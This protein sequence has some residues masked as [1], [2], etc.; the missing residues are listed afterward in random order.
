LRHRAAFLDAGHFDLIAATIAEHVRQ[1]DTSAWSILDAGSGT[2]HHLANIAKFFSP[3]VVGLGLDSS[4]DAARKAARHWPTL[5][6]AV[7]DLWTEWPVQDAAIDLLLSI[8]AP[9]NFPEVARV[10]RPAGRL[11]L[12]YP[13]TD[14]MVELRD[15]FGLMRR[16]EDADKRYAKMVKRFVGPPNMHRLRWQTVLDDAA[17][18]S[19]IMMGPNAR[20]I[21]A[22]TLHGELGPIAV[23]FEI[24]V[25][26]A[27]KKRQNPACF[28][29]AFDDREYHGCRNRRN[30]R[31]SVP[32][33]PRC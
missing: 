29:N 5:A 18:H 4:R 16:R 24:T 20:H 3:D 27:R 19:A 33:P 17:I 22:S 13:G 12:V 10:L 9:K 2:G 28:K 7:A 15:R 11:A 31:S 8:F 30:R 25:L 32:Q 1:S 21:G 14:H 23:T 26:L 6:F